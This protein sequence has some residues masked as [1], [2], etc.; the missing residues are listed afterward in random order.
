MSVNRNELRNIGFNV[1]SVER[2]KQAWDTGGLINEKMPPGWFIILDP[3]VNVIDD[4]SGTELIALITKPN[5]EN[6]KMKYD[7]Y[8]LR[9]NGQLCLF[10]SD[11]EYKQIEV[12]DKIGLQDT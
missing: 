2:Q 12:G 7:S 6:I 5:G 10:F 11:E 3:P 8:Q 9:E 1:V 4:H